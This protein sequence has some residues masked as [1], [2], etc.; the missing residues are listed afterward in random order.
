MS[1]PRM[2]DTSGTF[3]RGPREN[4]VIQDARRS[5]NRE[6][7]LKA[8]NSAYFLRVCELT[9]LVSVEWDSPSVLYDIG[10]G[11]PGAN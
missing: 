1:S 5:D 9:T 11:K 4:S 2:R 6:N 3:M 10:G 7:E 8:A